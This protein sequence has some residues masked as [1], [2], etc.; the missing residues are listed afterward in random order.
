[1]IRLT[2]YFTLTAAALSLLFM[3]YKSVIAQSKNTAR[4]LTSDGMPI[5]CGSKP[6][7]VSTSE[8]RDA[9]KMQPFEVME[10]ITIADISNILKEKTSPEVSKIEENYLHL[11]YRTP[12]FKFPDDVEFTI[13]D[14]KLL[15][16]SQSREGHSDLGKNR[17]R[18]N[19]ISTHLRGAGVI[20]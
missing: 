8:Q 10:G 20:K 18:L 6:N 9:Y 12:I 16:R 15:F 4:G 17:S 1:M 11:T 14:G 2:F 5:T 3:A 19:E 7:C 13:Q